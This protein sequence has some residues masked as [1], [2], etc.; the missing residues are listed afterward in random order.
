M[1]SSRKRALGEADLVLVAGLPLDFRLGYGRHIGRRARLV[2]VNLDRG[3]LFQNRLPQL[4]VRA[5]PG[6]FIEA[7]AAARPA[8]AADWIDWRTTL[9]GR[10]RVKDAECLE[11]CSHV[12]ELVLVVEGLQRS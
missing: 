2:A 10:D 1:R 6:R 4:A 8:A 3:A 12:E 5:R 7:L 11:H 9:R